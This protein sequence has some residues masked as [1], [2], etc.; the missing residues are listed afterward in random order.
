MAYEPI[1]KTFEDI[2]RAQAPVASEALRMHGDLCSQLGLHLHG[3]GML[4]PP[5]PPEWKHADG[6]KTP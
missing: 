4:A 3:A 6:G 5:L 1:H 2:R